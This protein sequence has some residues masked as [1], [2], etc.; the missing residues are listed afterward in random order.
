MKALTPFALAGNFFDIGP[1][2]GGRRLGVFKDVWW[3][4]FADASIPFEKVLSYGYKL[5]PITTAQID[6]HEYGSYSL[7]PKE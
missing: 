7:V 3:Y 2:L 5:Q 1:R 4:K 6:S